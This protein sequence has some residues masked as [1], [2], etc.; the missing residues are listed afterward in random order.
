MV[1][2]SRFNH[3]LTFASD[4][5]SQQVRKGS[6]VPYISHLLGVCSLV[7][8]YGGDE[9][10]AIA[11]LL[12][13]AIEDQGGAATREKIRYHFGEKVTAIVDS[14]TDA[15]QTPKPPWRERKE[16]YIA[17]IR[18]MSAEAALVSAADKLHNASS[19]LKD[20]RLVG[21]E[22]WERF[23]GKKEGTLWYY[24]ALVNAFRQRE[25]TPIV[26]ELTR[27]VEELDAI[28]LAVP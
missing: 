5:H 21:E 8:E 2:S 15:D 22:I 11:A 26:E 9:D 4:L 10:C 1:L 19:I 17:H 7:L 27:V 3:A 20:Y 28:A 25:V 16:A 13:D 24:R 14:C 12:H 18:E 23:R 6:Q